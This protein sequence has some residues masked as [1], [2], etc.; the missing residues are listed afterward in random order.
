[1]IEVELTYEEL[2]MILVAMEDRW[3]EHIKIFSQFGD[4]ENRARNEYPKQYA[5]LAKLRDIR[6]VH[7][8]KKR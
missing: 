2:Q 8:L 1:M 4:P 5:I 7:N 6:V 3:Q